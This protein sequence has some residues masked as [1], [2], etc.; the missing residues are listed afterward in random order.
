MDQFA[1]FNWQLIV[2][3]KPLPPAYMDLVSSFQLDQSH[4]GA[5]MLTINWSAW[6]A[7]AA[8]FRVVGENILGPGANLV[9][10]TG[11]GH[12][13]A[14]KGRYDL[15]RFEP[16]F[17]QDSP[18]VTMIAYDGLRRLL[19]HTDA[20]H[21]G[22]PPTY[23]RVASIIAE[24]HGMAI[25][26]QTSKA[27]RYK[28]RTI[29][30]RRKVKV[31]PKT[32]EQKAKAALGITEYKKV[33]SQVQVSKKLIKRAGETDL[34]LLKWAA[35]GAGYLWPRMRY[36]NGQDTLVFSPPDL[37]GQA[38]RHGAFRFHYIPTQGQDGTILSIRPSLSTANL[39]RSV[40]ATGVDPTTGRLR[41]VEAELV[42]SDFIRGGDEGLRI[43]TRDGG[44]ID[45]Q[46]KKIF[47]KPGLISLDILGARS[48]GDRRNPASGRVEQVMAR[49]MIKPMV[50]ADWAGSL[51]ELVVA[52]L[53][54]RLSL[55]I[56]AEAEAANL[57]GLD[58]IE[59]GDV[60]QFVG[61]TAEYDGWYMIRKILHSFDR[62]AGHRAAM[63][64]QKLGEVREGERA[65]QLRVK[66]P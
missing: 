49:E 53:R 62:S 30:R 28:K 35:S 22:T 27:I 7:V 18:T 50:V 31:K 41:I 5:D 54:T 61:T 34:Q 16:T 52:W 42:G 4:D 29:T 57:V 13:L 15:H 63:T 19:D 21:L 40:R 65:T 39:P 38:T 36:V 24:Q 37:R 14:D 45:K 11:Y 3:G 46:K 60:H 48:A 20:W 58:R 23:D 12:N 10:R 47:N 43:T 8:R 33:S 25:Q 51:E 9:L 55:Y 56:T 6:D 17:G 64:I 1:Q 26:T 2:N 66:R 32:L 59:P 44:K